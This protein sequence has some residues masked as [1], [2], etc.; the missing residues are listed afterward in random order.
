[1]STSPPASSVHSRD[2]SVDGTAA[3]V[4]VTNSEGASAEEPSETESEVTT[5]EE[6]DPLA[7][8]DTVLVAAREEGVSVEEVGAA[9]DGPSSAGVDP[10]PDAHAAAST[11]HAT[12]T[13]NTG[14]HAC[15]E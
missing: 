10:S 3:A 11:E 2:G 9:D 8:G 6:V 13:P 12:K 7:D 14:N 15:V 5:S 4:V 1:M